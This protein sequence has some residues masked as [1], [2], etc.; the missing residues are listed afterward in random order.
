MFGVSVAVTTAVILGTGTMVMSHGSRLDK[1]EQHEVDTD[2]AN[3]AALQGIN[4]NLNYIRS[5]I[6]NGGSHGNIGSP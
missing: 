3:A 6:D 1:I 4:A 5:R 2:A